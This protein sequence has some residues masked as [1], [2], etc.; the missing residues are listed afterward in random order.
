MAKAMSAETMVIVMTP[1]DRS[2]FGVMIKGGEDQ[3]FILRNPQ[4]VLGMLLAAEAA[5]QDGMPE[6][7]KTDQEKVVSSERARAELELRASYFTSAM[8]W[9]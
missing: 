1:E 4:E 8:P 9:H 2:L 6:E 5:E 7:D 3:L